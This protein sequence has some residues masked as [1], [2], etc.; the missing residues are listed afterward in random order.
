MGVS[1]F[2]LGIV[3]LTSGSKP[4]YFLHCYFNRFFNGLGPHF[5]IDLFIIFGF[6]L[7]QI[8]KYAESQKTRFRIEGI[9]KIKIEDLQKA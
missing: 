2:I 3:F 6:I 7:Y 8:S 1:E 4:I 9:A 5:F